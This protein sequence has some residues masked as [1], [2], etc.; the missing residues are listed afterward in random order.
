MALLREIVC[1]EVTIRSDGES[2]VDKGDNKRAQV[3]DE[4]SARCKG[5]AL[6]PVAV[7]ERRKALINGVVLSRVQ[8]RNCRGEP[9]AGRCCKRVLR[10]NAG[11][12]GYDG[13]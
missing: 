11:R 13:E 6:G 10:V 12:M 7:R 1:T 8:E 4:W 3:P 2:M 5:D 9:T